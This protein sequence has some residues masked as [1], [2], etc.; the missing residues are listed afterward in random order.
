ML[1]QLSSTLTLICFPQTSY[2]AVIVAVDD[3]DHPASQVDPAHFREGSNYCPIRSFV[4]VTMCQDRVPIDETHGRLTILGILFRR[5]TLA[6]GPRAKSN[7][8]GPSLHRT[9]GQ[10]LD[11]HLS[12]VWPS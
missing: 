12:R 1:A 9:A 6:S 2:T 11:T 4:T 7:I 3:K 5:Y 10:S 8:C